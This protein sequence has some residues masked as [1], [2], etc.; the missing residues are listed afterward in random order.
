MGFAACCF[1]NNKVMT[2]PMINEE[3]FMIDK[4]L[5]TAFCI[6]AGITLL[7]QILLLS[8]PY[9][10]KIEFDT[11]CHRYVMSM[12]YEGGLSH[13]DHQVL[14]EDLENRG[15]DIRGLHGDKDAAYGSLM[16]LEVDAIWSTYRFRRLFSLEEVDLC[17]AY[18]AQIPARV[19]SDN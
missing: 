19:L 7:M 12:S 16:S 9:F 15:F 8:L 13:H 3:V 14:L 17:F 5:V 6:A 11:V 1:C 10:K 18:S 4:V 2:V